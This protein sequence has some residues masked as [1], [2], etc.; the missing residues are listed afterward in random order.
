MSLIFN[1]RPLALVSAIGIGLAVIALTQA[2]VM[3]AEHFQVL[4]SPPFPAGSPVSPVL[5][6]KD[7]AF[8]GTA[9]WQ[10][11]NLSGL[12]SF[13]VFRMD[14]NPTSRIRPLV[15]IFSRRK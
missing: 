11:G 15:Q 14:A 4:T 8:Y 7:G 5:R 2:E 12:P 9:S 3:S 10:T 6:G 1:E 13:N